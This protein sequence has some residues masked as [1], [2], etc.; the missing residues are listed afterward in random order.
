MPDGR[1]WVGTDGA[2]LHLFDPDSGTFQ[3]FGHDADDPS[4]LGSDTV[5]ALHLEPSGRLWIGSRGGGLATLSGP[6]ETQRARF[7]VLGTDDG[8]PD[9]VSLR[10]PLGH[11]RRPAG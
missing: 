3:R 7:H 11:R 1:L 6:P 8:L 4:G 5:L 9:D 10:H 2:G